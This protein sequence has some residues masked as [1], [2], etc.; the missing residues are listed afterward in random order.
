MMRTNMIVM[1]IHKIKYVAKMMRVTMI[2]IIHIKIITIKK[3]IN[4][5]TIKMNKV[6]TKTMQQLGDNAYLLSEN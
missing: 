3:I 6:K 2:K 5:R 1:R 4:I